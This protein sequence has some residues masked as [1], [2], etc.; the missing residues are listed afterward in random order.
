MIMVIPKSPVV[1]IALLQSNSSHPR[2]LWSLSACYYHVSQPGTHDIVRLMACLPV[3]TIV[4]VSMPH[5]LVRNTTCPQ[6][7]CHVQITNT[8]ISNMR[9]YSLITL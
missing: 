9:H 3:K 5:V 4:T 2:F 6:L 7:G 8:L 1:A